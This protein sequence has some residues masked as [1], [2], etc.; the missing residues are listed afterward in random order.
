MSGIYQLHFQRHLIN[1]LT[2][3]ACPHTTRI[4]AEPLDV[5]V[6]IAQ[7]ILNVLGWRFRGIT[8]EGL[9]PKQKHMVTKFPFKEINK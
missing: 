8:H 1:V 7:Y 5:V 3:Y 4:T 9:K 6:N 2:Y